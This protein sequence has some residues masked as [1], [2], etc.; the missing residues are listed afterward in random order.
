MVY[1]QPL[2]NAKS[3]DC[4][5]IELLLRWHNARQGWIPPDV[6]IP[7]AEPKPYRAAY[8]FRNL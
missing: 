2:I 6:F 5:G 3:G 8:A 1:C 4:D 7:L